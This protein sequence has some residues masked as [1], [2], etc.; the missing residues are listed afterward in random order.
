VR[1]S[2]EADNLMAAFEHPSMQMTLRARAARGFTVLEMMIVMMIIVI[3]AA[4]SSVR[5]EQSVVQ[6]HEAALRRDLYVMREAIQNYTFDKEAAPTSLEDLHASGYIGDVPT[7]PI[8]RQKDWNTDS[9]N[10]VLSPDQI[11]GGICDVHSASD[12]VSP[13]EQKP[14]SEF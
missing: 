12:K 3:L 2:T 14:Y 1:L 5:Y 8:T 7:D 9:C 4:M 10:N 11:A 13:V 6:A